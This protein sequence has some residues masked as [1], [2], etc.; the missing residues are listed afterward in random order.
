MIAVAH[1]P[2]YSH[3]GGPMLPVI[4]FSWRDFE[5]VVLTTASVGDLYEA[6]R[7]AAPRLLIIHERTLRWTAL[8]VPEGSRR[9]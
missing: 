7:D 5:P 1:P 3:L 9:R 4:Q 2:T 6:A 8:A